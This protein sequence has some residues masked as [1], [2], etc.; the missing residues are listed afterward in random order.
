MDQDSHQ[1][2]ETASTGAASSTS[3][4]S[5]HYRWGIKEA[6][7]VRTTTTSTTPF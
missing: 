4:M 6:K 5:G 3:T 1:H 7:Y 2:S